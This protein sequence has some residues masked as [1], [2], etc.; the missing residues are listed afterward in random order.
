MQRRKRTCAFWQQL[1]ICS[2]VFSG[3]R[4]TNGQFSVNYRRP[5]AEMMLPQFRR[6]VCRLVAQL[7]PSTDGRSSISDR[8][9]SGRRL[10]L[11][12]IRHPFQSLAMPRTAASLKSFPLPSCRHFG[13]PSALSRN[14]RRPPT[15][16]TA[17]GYL[18]AEVFRCLC[19][20]PSVHLISAAAA[21]AAVCDG[22]ALVAPVVHKP[23]NPW[24]RG[25]ADLRG[26]GLVNPP[27]AQ[28]PSFNSEVAAVD[29][30]RRARD[31]GRAPAA[32]HRRLSLPSMICS[33]GGRLPVGPDGLSGE[34]TSN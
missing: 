30:R 7:M 4:R 32:D 17:T 27:A 29:E 12:R 9:V 21:A 24:W 2:S 31:R 28:P 22:G 13:M 20:M 8:G 26:G 33:V 14:R 3:R 10:P 6:F 25:S 34:L 18:G 15:D 19:P 11:G 16:L 1:V 23:S 5:S